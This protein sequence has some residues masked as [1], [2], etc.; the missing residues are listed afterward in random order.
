[1]KHFGNKY[2]IN[3]ICYYVDQLFTSSEKGVRDFQRVQSDKVLLVAGS[4]IAALFHI[5][6]NA[7]A[8]VLR[9][10]HSR[11]GAYPSEVAVVSSILVN[12]LSPTV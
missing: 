2:S 8:D 3:F 4:I 12:Y 7:I 9:E 5:Q 10:L 6:P 1:M 11:T